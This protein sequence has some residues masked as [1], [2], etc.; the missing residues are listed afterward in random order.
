MQ[1]ALNRSIWRTCCVAII[2]VACALSASAQTL[3]KVKMGYFPALVDTPVFVAQAQGIF[4]KNGLEVEMISFTTGPALMSALLSGSTQFS[5]GGG[6]LVTFPQ[7]ARGHNIRG[8][9][10]F[11]SESFYTLIARSNIPT[12]NKGKPYPAPM[13]DLKGKKVG[14]TALGALTAA[15][16]ETMARDAGL[17]VGEDI[18]IVAAGAVNTAISA[19]ENGSIDAYLSYQ[20]INQ[21]LDARNKGFYTVILSPQQLPSLLRVNLFNHMVTTQEYIASNPRTVQAMCRSIR[22][23]LQWIRVPGN[24]DATVAILEKALPGNPPGVISAALREALPSMTAQ[25]ETLGRITPAAVNNANEQ[26]LGLKYITQ[27]VS[28]ATYTYPE[29]NN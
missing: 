12:P 23:A 18:T 2:G 16:V 5:D 24:F 4:Q 19:L 15:M 28:F 22:E 20:P 21:L 29:C 8:I 26:L 3:T 11:W 9:A 7:V 10:N 17:K 25:P 13:L 6:G 14:V 27:G 1:L